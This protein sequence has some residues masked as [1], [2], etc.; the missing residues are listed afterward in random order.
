MSIDPSELGYV[1]YPFT[2]GSSLGYAGLDVFLGEPGAS[3]GFVPTQV[4]V[5]TWDNGG[6]LD[7][8]SGMGRATIA[9]HTSVAAGGEGA[10]HVAPGF[11][12]VEGHGGG[13]L[14][15]Y[16]F[17]GTLT[18]RRHGAMIA[19]HLASPAPIF[20]LSEEGL[21]WSENGILRVVDGLES[22][23]ATLRAQSA[24]RGETTFDLLLARTDPRLLYAVG[25][26]LAH[27]SFQTLPEVLRTE[28]YWDEYSVLVRALQDARKAAW[29]P[30]NAS[31]PAQLGKDVGGKEFSRG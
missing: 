4:I 12:T 10:Y 26:D 14:E 18:Y 30:E 7:G 2:D 22:E 8:G 19:C 5:C 13:E 28:H 21:N 17:G 31:L 16:C 15:A 1:F 29:W 3:E 11:V 27:R 6:V 23:I 25:L 9:A 24:A 20:N